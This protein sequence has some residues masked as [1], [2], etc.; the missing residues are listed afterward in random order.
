VIM[1]SMTFWL[2]VKSEKIDSA[3][4]EPSSV[5]P[6]TI[7]RFDG[8]I[9]LSVPRQSPL[10]SIIRLSRVSRVSRVSCVSCACTG[11]VVDDE[12]KEGH[13]VLQHVSVVGRQLSDEIPQPWNRRLPIR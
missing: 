3:L 1:A 10:P 7:A 11:F 2:A 4:P 5:G 13:E 12:L 8:P 9:L 6:N